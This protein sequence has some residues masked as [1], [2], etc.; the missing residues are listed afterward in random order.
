[1]GRLSKLRVV[2]PVL[3][4]LA[5]GY[6]NAAFIGDQLLPFVNLDKEGGK[7]P[8]FA[9]SPTGSIRRT[10][11]ALT[12]AWTSTIWNTRSTTGKTLKPRS[13]CRRTPPTVWSRAFVCATR[14][15]SQ[16]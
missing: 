9:P 12:S 8:R 4:A 2:D 10:L 6:S 1:M 5:L 3:S 11:T 13:H 7:I 14:P 15:W 16:A